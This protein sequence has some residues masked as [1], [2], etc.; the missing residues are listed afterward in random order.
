MRRPATPEQRASDPAFALGGADDRL[1]VDL[2]G[3]DLTYSELRARIA[4]EQPSSGLVRATGRPVETLV[5]I[6]A[7]FASGRPVLVA[8]P[9]RPPDLAGEPPAGAGLLVTTSG[10]TGRPRVVCRT[11]ASWT[12]SFEPF[13]QVTGITAADTV[14]L[15]GPLQSSMQ[16][17]GAVHALSAGATLT[18]RVE[19]A[20]A[21]HAAPSTLER[22]LRDG[23]R[24]GLVV[25]AGARLSDRVSA[26]AAAAGVAVV[27]YYGAAEL[28]FVAARRAPEAL[29]AYPGVEIELRNGELWARSPY[30]ASGY[31]GEPGPMRRDARGFATVGDRAEQVDGALRIAGRGD[32]AITT[33]GETVIAEDIEAILGEAPG[34]AGVVVVGLPH[35]R[36]GEVVAAVVELDGPVESLKQFARDTLG[37]AARPRLWYLA[38]IPRT[39]VGKPARGQ[40]IEELR[41]GRL[42]DRQLPWSE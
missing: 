22:L 40:V 19:S 31:L 30:L 13:S 28:S 20:T 21:V 26:A 25:V 15:T 27:E 5:A 17:F 37:A 41:A 39:G 8:D 2:D 9:H 18:D 7:A 3:E 24:P 35:P 38:P 12:V 34:V 10:S 29:T 33:G 4:D 16:L 42:T 1:A 36:L 14:A 11:L 23:H 32:S 6:L